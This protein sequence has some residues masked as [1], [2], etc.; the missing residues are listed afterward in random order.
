MNRRIQLVVSLMKNDLRRAPSLNELAASVNLSASRLRH[1]F[2]AETGMTPAQ[3]LK[4]LRMRAAKELL[5]ST[6]LSVKEIAVGIGYEH[7]SHFVR[8][9]RK[10]YDISPAQYR[11]R[12]HNDKHSARWKKI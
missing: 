4:S 2:K 8:D 3:Y 1:I 10:V 6:F 12:H 7:P 9:F 5:E 11:A